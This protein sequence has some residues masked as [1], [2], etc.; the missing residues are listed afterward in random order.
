LE[1]G[2]H[3]V[4]ELQVEKVGVYMSLATD[5]VTLL[6]ADVSVAAGFTTISHAWETD[7][8]DN[9]EDD[10]IPG[11]FVFPGKHIVAVSEHDGFVAQ[12]VAKHLNCFIVATH[13]AIDERIAEVRA[14]GLG[15]QY[16]T[17]HDELELL[18]GEPVSLKGDFLWWMD[19]YITRTQIRQ[20]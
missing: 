11:V 16:D 20:S 6:E 5:F 8:I 13:A 15:W 10:V 17:T 18:S 19:V 2:I 3:Q 12:K 14:A 7:P 4:N 9:L 1:S